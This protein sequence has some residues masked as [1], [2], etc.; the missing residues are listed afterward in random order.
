[1][2]A[3]QHNPVFEVFVGSHVDSNVSALEGP[4]LSYLSFSSFHS[5][6]LNL[7]SLCSLES[8]HKNRV[9]LVLT[10]L[11]QHNKGNDNA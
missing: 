5:S 2:T 4:C 9:R 6:F 3:D 11:Q 1:M 7:F 10:K 8:F